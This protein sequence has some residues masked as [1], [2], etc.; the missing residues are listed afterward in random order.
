[1][2]QLLGQCLGLISGPAY[3]S[4]RAATSP[5]FTH[6][7][8]P[9]YLDRISHITAAH[10]TAI[11]SASNGN[12]RKG[13]INPVADLR[14]LPFWI[15][16]DVLYGNL[17]PQLKTE[18]LSLTELRESLWKRMINGGMTRFSFSQY[19]PTE[20]RLNLREFKSRWK[21]FNDKAYQACLTAAMEDSTPIV[22]L[23]M[24]VER[25]SIEME[26]V[27][28]TLDEMLFANL[29]VT[30]GGL[31][32][33][34]MFLAAHPEVQG[35]IREEIQRARKG[36][37]QKW[38]EYLATSSTLLHASILESSRLKPLAAFTVPQA[39]PTDR[40][41]GDG[42]RIPKGTNIVVD[43]GALNIANTFW[44]QDGHVYRPSRFL[45][46]EASK[47]RYEFWRFGFG[48]RQCLGRYLVDLLLRVV[49]AHL[50]ENYEL[51]LLE[52]VTK[53]EKDGGS[54]I[55]HPHPDTE[56]RCRPISGSVG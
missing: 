39:A 2:G 51:G 19:L 27:L 16:A 50:V 37:D 45:E 20:A 41:V 3:T 34:L 22:S 29:D 38:A 53:W 43:T 31:S 11:S 1:M 23:Y 15:L 36:E 18:L 46:R 8:A 44:G 52:D 47:M 7:M 40:V 5:P 9:D 25:G 28:Q 30:M 14:M 49:V 54:W 13:V 4:L 56:L 48:P 24:H 6:K 12:L 26:E 33:N 35:R 55:T 42:Y 21:E 10:F 17:S 32:W